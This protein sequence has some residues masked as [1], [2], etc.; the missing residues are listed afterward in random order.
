MRAIEDVRQKILIV[1]DEHLNRELLNQ[2]LDAAGYD[3]AEARNGE[4]AL[5]RAREWKPDV[6]LLDVMMPSLDGF[7][8]CRRLKAARATL[9]IPV[10]FMTA[11]SDKADK[12]RAFEAGGADYVTKPFEIEEVLARVKVHVQLNLT[13][14][15]LVDRN[16][17]LA[18]EIEKRGRAQQTIEYLRKEI[19]SEFGFDEI[20]GMSA[21]LR[22]ALEK[23]NQVAKTD[24]TVLILGETGTGKE[25]FARAIHRHSSR[26]DGPMIKLNCAAL[27][28]ELVESELFGHE[29]GAFTGAVASRKGRFELAD[30]GTIF[31]DEIAELSPSAQAKLLRVLQERELERL[32]GTGA[33]A[34]DVRVVAA[35]N[36]N[37]QAAVERGEFRDDLYYRLNVFPI[38][39]P[40]LRERTEDVPL[41]VRHFTVE[42]GSRMGKT[43]T[44]I[45][46]DALDGLARYQ[47]PGN[48]RE[49]QNIVER[50]AILSPGPVLEIR[51]LL[52]NDS[53]P[54]DTTLVAVERAHI[55][56][57]LDNSQWQIEGR[58]GAAR[59]LGMNPSTLRGKMRKLGIRKD[60][61]G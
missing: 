35:T 45:E 58:S 23:L 46:S 59:Q 42:F 47:W 27:P 52:V 54:C 50:A 49:L 36:K 13:R 15:M 22:A 26:K 10:I 18:E 56:R 11:L 17:R 6:V 28:G 24:T 7:E 8:V 37:L 12:L 33:I 48:I 32:G 20:I 39:V 31:L 1:D 38:T 19:E 16:R 60:R 43:F 44:S 57:V 53:A 40:A 3:I 55:C 21:V 2:E 4:E 5:V 25:L 29:K 30:G 9:E 14:R 41:L 34:V 61:I 51:D